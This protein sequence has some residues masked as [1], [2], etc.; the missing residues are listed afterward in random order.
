MRIEWR[1]E[2]AASYDVRVESSGWNRGIAEDRGPG[3]SILLVLPIGRTSPPHPSSRASPFGRPHTKR[4]ILLDPSPQGSRC[5][6][7]ASPEV[8]RAILQALAYADVFDYPLTAAEV[9]RY[10]IG[11]TASRRAVQLRLAALVASG[12]LVSRDDLY[13][14]PGREG[15]AAVRSR[16]AEASAR[17]WPEGIRYGRALGQLP[18]VRM[19][20]VTGSLA[21]NNVEAGSDIDYLVVTAAGRV[22]IG[23]G[24]ASL[25]RRV[26]QRRGVRICPNFVLSEESLA[27]RDRNLYTAHELMQMVPVTGHAVYRRMIELNR[28]AREYLPNLRGQPRA[29]WNGAHPKHPLTRL[30]EAAL[31]TPLGGWLDRLERSRLERKMIPRAESLAEVVYSADCCKDHTSPHGQRVLTVFAE[32]LEQVEVGVP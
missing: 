7:I 1:R 6:G 8:K 5:A 17:L 24:M 28:W 20:A 11:A 16:R 29:T 4:S 15:L 10:L 2:G 14:L 19:V 12:S 26:A 13:M 27:I 32:R 3:P 30:A 25:Y 21:L 18:Y 22:W 23:R 31:D 9:H